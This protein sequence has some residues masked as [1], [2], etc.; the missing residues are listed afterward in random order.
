MK[1]I[2]ILNS[3][4]KI[5]KTLLEKA[6]FNK[7]EFNK[8][9]SYL[10]DLQHCKDKAIQKRLMSEITKKGE[11][12]FSKKFQVSINK[13]YSLFIYAGNKIKFKNSMNY[14]LKNILE[15]NPSI[16]TVV[17]LFMGSGGSIAAI[18]EQLEKNDITDIIVSDLNE[19]AINVHKNVKEHP[20]EVFEEIQKIHMI[21]IQ[22]GEDVFSPSEKMM[23]ALKKLLN[24]NEFK[25]NYSSLET[26]AL[27]LFLNQNTYGGNYEVDGNAIKSD[28]TISNMNPTNYDDVK[29]YSSV[30]NL[31]HKIELYSKI[32]NSFNMIFLSEDCFKLMDTLRSDSH[33]LFLA[34]PPYLTSKSDKI[35][36]CE[37]NYNF[38]FE[39]EKML[40]YLEGTNFI[41]NNHMHK[42][43]D[44]TCKANNYNLIK[45][46]RRTTNA[47]NAHIKN[48]YVYEYIMYG[49]TEISFFNEPEYK[50]IGD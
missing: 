3:F 7:K 17:D 46:R 49:S 20:Q 26:S 34:D 2:K 10:S 39:H 23:K 15:E 33:V 30:L 45:L 18:S 6:S 8:T 36:G 1:T 41:Y 4:E 31:K 44:K 11:I 29:Y 13:D 50:V 19:T 35:E 43:I 24:A 27:F 47:N 22:S 40:D 25:G 5:S 28:I 38:I 48:A 14:A 12:D 42:V 21:I 37:Q 9:F 16:N 32:Y